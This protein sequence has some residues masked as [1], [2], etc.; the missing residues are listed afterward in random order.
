MTVF[1]IGNT[2]ARQVCAHFGCSESLPTHTLTHFQW[3][4][5]VTFIQLHYTVDKQLKQAIQNDIQRLLSIGC[6]RGLRH[7]AQLPVRGQRTH[8]NAQTRK[9]GRK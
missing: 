1:G 7:N 3:D 4:Q 5:I 2:K 6:Y 9:K 8:S